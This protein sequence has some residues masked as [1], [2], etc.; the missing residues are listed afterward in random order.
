ML[1]CGSLCPEFLRP[2]RNPENNL[3]RDSSR[4][5]TGLDRQQIGQSDLC[6]HALHLLEQGYFAD[7]LFG[8]FFHPLVVFPDAPV[9]RFDLF[10]TAAPDLAQLGAQSLGELPLT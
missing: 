8:D 4:T 6:S 3:P 5:D 10:T 7:T 2:G 1:F 9:Q